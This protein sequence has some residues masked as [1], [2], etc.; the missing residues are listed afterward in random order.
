M[1]FKIVTGRPSPAVHHERA[2]RIQPS[3]NAEDRLAAGENAHRAPG[4]RVERRP[5][6]AE[7]RESPA[8]E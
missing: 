6:L 5:F 3:R 8:L 4:Q 2:V 7:R 1:A